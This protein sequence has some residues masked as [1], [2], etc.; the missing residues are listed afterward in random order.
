MTTAGSPPAPLLVVC[1]GTP[2][3]AVPGSDRRMTDELLRYARVLWV[4][5]EFS[6]VTRPELRQGT[7]RRLRPSMDEPVPG[8]YRLKPVAPPLHTRPPVR[9]ASRM[10]VRAQI[11]QALRRLGERPYAV[12]DCRMAGCCK[13]G[14]RACA[15]SS[16][17]PTTSSAGPS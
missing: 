1:A 11:D 16:T 17:A 2:W 10:L 12:L 8:L 14:R 4:D 7:G 9:P 5:P 13:A 15:G 6:V 3:D